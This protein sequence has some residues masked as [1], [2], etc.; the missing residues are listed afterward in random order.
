MSELV[1]PEDLKKLLAS[2]EKQQNS[3]WLPPE[4]TGIEVEE[5]MELIERIARLSA[6]N[7]RLKE[8]PHVECKRMV[9]ELTGEL[10][11]LEAENG[12]IDKKYHDLCEE[13]AE[14]DLD[15][16]KT[17]VSTLQEEN[18]TLRQ[19][20]EEMG[21]AVSDD[22]ELK[23]RMIIM[24]EDHRLREALNGLITARARGTEG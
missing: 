5:V 13:V 24:G 2:C 19:R 23:V 6:E 1:I 18:A 16:L 7:A 3:P 9:Y 22:E 15:Y 4:M 12:Q 8:K 14:S 21:R 20:V 11:R 17:Q 10:A